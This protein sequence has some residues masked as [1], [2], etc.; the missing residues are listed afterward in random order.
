M[1]ERIMKKQ[2][3]KVAGYLYP[4]TRKKH[5]KFKKADNHAYYLKRQKIRVII[6]SLDALQEKAFSG[7][8]VLADPNANVEMQGIKRAL[9]SELRD[10]KEKLTADEKLLIHL[11]YDEE[12]TEDEAGKVFGISQQAI[13]KRHKKIIAKLTKIMKVK[14][15]WL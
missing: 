15:F 13:S 3:I 6:E 14:N 4:V 7:I 5:R 9:L 12:K 10:A 2:Q 1:E 8:D 11:L